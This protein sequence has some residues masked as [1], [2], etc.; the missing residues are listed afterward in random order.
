M[1]TQAKPQYLKKPHYHQ[2]VISR[3]YLA[4]NLLRK[5]VLSARAKCWWGYEC[6]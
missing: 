4:S 3:W 6:L 5:N 2:Y 1:P